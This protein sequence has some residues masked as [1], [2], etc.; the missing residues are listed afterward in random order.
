MS[1]SQEELT[2]IA[3]DYVLNRPLNRP[4]TNILDILAIVIPY[5]VI[6]VFLSKSLIFYLQTERKFF[7]YLCVHFI[8]FFLIAK[9]LFIQCIKVY[10]H[11]APEKIRRSCLCKPTCSEYAILVLKK[12]ILV[13]AIYKI[14]DRIFFTCSG[15]KLIYK[16]DEP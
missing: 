5:F 6:S 9:P 10:Q 3:K 7:V 4:K 1:Y 14:L 11:Y 16:I 13:V 8:N 12:Y 2:E 15:D